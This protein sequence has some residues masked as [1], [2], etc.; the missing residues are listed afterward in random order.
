M[1]ALVGLVR[2]DLP[3]G[4]VIRLS[5]GGEVRWGA[6]LFVPFDPSYGALGSVES[7]AEGIGVEV[8]ALQLTLLPPSSA[9]AA[10]LVQPGSQSARVRLWLARYDP[11]SMTVISAGSAMFDGFLDTATLVRGPGKL[12]LRCQVVAMLERLF[13]LNIGNSLNQTFH[14]SIW[15]GE[16]GEDQATGLSLPDAWGVEGPVQATTYYSGGGG[17]ETWAGRGTIRLA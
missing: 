11:A 16:T 5:E 13:E 17:A 6:D 8:P 3:G 1:T 7:L 15:P 10:S 14:K 4:P 12:E 9:S 2:I